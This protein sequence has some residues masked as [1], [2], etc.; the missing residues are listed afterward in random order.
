MLTVN[1][2]EYKF[3]QGNL[4]EWL[5]RHNIEPEFT[6]VEYNGGIVTRDEYASIALKPGDRM[7]ILR[8]VGGG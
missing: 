6:A 5:R 2:Q 7:E 4:E 1:G 8:F 3:E